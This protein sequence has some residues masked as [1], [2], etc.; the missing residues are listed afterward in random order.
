MTGCI[1]SIIMTKSSGNQTVTS[2]TY[3]GLGRATKVTDALSD[4][5]MRQ[6]TYYQISTENT[7]FHF[8]R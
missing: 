5:R 3:D 1:L 7:A 2:I 6:K 8:D 4:T